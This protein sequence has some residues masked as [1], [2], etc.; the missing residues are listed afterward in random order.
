METSKIIISGDVERKIFKKWF[1][2]KKELDLNDLILEQ[3]DF[4]LTLWITFIIN[5]IFTFSYFFIKD[6]TIFLTIFI[7][8]LIANLFIILIWLKFIFKKIDFLYFFINK[9]IVLYWKKFFTLEKE[10]N[11]NFKDFLIFLWFFL[12]FP[13]VFLINFFHDLIYRKYINFHKNIVKLEKVSEEINILKRKFKKFSEEISKWNLFYEKMKKDLSILWKKVNE[14]QKINEKIKINLKKL[15]NLKLLS[16][17]DYEIF[18]KENLVFP[19]NILKKVLE[20]NLEETLKNIEINNNSQNE[21]IKFLQK[22]LFLQKNILEKEI[23][24][25]EE[26]IKK[27]KN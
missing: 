17:E 6:F 9:K 22:R 1:F 5:I 14:S 7:F 3:E 23:L 21:Q 8:I 26:K 24:N 2:A 10:N 15:E 20:N 18:L 11:Y 13:F 16:L 19:L 4:L 12:I 25:L 27:I